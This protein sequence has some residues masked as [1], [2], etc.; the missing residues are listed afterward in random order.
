MGGH[1]NSERPRQALDEHK[2]VMPADRFA[3]ADHQGIDVWLPTFLEV[4]A[5]ASGARHPNSQTQRDDSQESGPAMAVVVERVVPASGNLGLAGRQFWIGRKHAGAT[6]RFEIETEWVHLFIGVRKLKS[7]TCRFTETERHHLAAEGAVKAAT[8]RPLRP[9]PAL[10]RVL[11]VERTV[12]LDGRIRLGGH[13]FAV[14]ML[15]AGQRVGVYLDED[16]PMLIFDIETRVLLRARPNPFTF[17]EA[18]TF[19]LRRPVG[20]IPDTKHMTVV[21]HRRTGRAG[22]IMVARQKV[23]LGTSYAFQTVTVEVRERTLTLLLS[24]GETRV[25][26]RANTT[27]VRR[28]KASATDRITEQF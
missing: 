3:P 15:L 25:I 11:E 2:P 22:T 9:T 13:A 10:K 18:Q 6:V 23:L 27:P 21:V 8:P 12:S 26:Q 24:D 1:Y 14:S 20:R 16:S 7:L 5:S 28:M 19:K 17:E 4:A